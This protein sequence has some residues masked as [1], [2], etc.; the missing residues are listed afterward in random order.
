[1]FCKLNSKIGAIKKGYVCSEN[2]APY[3]VSFIHIDFDV[4][5]EQIP[6]VVASMYGT[7][8]ATVPHRVSACN[9]TTTGFD[10]SFY[11]GWAGG[12]ANIWASWIAIA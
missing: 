9:V 6:T 1:M 11:N 2:T 3:N 7:T 10:I 8:E 5:F 12:Y 4:F